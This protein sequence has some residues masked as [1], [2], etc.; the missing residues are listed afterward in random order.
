MF[1]KHLHRRSQT[2]WKAKV[3]FDWYKTQKPDVVRLLESHIF[4]SIDITPFYIVFQSLLYIGILCQFIGSKFD[5]Q[6]FVLYFARCVSYT[7][8]GSLTKL[9]NI[10]SDYKGA[11]IPRY[12]C[13]TSSMIE[14]LR[15]FAIGK[16]NDLAVPRPYF[17]HAL[18]RTVA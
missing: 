7:Y 16:S 2:Q 18:Q 8:I 13:T 1:Q 6:Q 12:L 11:P 15:K 4:I 5:H 3:L 17:S 14:S 9:E 10:L